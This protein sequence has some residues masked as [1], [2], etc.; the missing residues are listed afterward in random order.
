M[1]DG[2]EYP[3]SGSYYGQMM[4]C[5]SFESSSFDEIAQQ[6]IFDHPKIYD[7]HLP[8][9]FEDSYPI[10]ADLFESECFYEL[11]CERIIF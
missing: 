5:A 6:L 8:A 7:K 9:D 2:Y 1:E 4:I 11:C 3:S 10:V